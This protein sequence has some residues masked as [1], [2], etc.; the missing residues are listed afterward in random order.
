MS[1]SKVLM[2]DT[3]DKKSRPRELDVG[4][5][6]LMRDTYDKK[7]RPREL[8]VGS[9]YLCETPMTRSLDLGS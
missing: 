9:R 3:Y 7:S 8:D 2:K 4:S 1:G 5:R 6:V